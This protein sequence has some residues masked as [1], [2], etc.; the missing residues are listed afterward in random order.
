M[1]AKKS[2]DN[3]DHRSIAKCN[4]TGY[5]CAVEMMHG[6]RCAEGKSGL[7]LNLWTQRRSFLHRVFYVRKVEEPQ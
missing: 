3:C 1:N 4:R 7:K 6:G 5:F 2:C